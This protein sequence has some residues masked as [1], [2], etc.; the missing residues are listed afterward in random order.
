MDRDNHWERI[1]KAYQLLTT[2]TQP[3][4]TNWKEVLE[5]YYHQNFTDEY[6]P[7]TCLLADSYIKAGDGVIF[8]IPVLTALAN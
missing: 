8:L 4:F 6:I 3:T 7:P 2:S 5:H 1:E